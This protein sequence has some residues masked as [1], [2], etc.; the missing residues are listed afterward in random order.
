MMRG[1]PN[2]TWG[3]WRLHN[4]QQLYYSL[5]DFPTSWFSLLPASPLCDWVPVSH[6]LP[7]LPSLPSSNGV[8]LTRHTNWINTHLWLQYQHYQQSTMYLDA[9]LQNSLNG[10]S[11]VATFNNRESLGTRLPSLKT[12]QFRGTITGDHL[13]RESMAVHTSLLHIFSFFM[14][15]TR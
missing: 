6:I 15:S 11:F 7:L 3:V 10:T 9:A 4:I 8:K 13:K 12:T 2:P 14:H 5:G 1:F